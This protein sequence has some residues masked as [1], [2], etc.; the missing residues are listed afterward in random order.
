MEI[1]A[2]S[3]K[4]HQTMR[5]SSL[6]TFKL[7]NA[8]C[9]HVSPKLQ[10]IPRSTSSSERWAIVMGIKVPY[11]EDLVMALTEDQLMSMMNLESI[12]KGTYMS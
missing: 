11:E 9:A 5:H 7:Y 10:V 4:H 12:T 3:T 6:C 2:V 8:R 1:M